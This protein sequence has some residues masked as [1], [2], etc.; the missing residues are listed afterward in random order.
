MFLNSDLL[1]FQAFLVR[2]YNLRNSLKISSPFDFDFLT[3][4]D[5]SRLIVK[6]RVEIAENVDKADLQFSFFDNVLPKEVL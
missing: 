5:L 2:E 3:D 6:L 1:I 4:E